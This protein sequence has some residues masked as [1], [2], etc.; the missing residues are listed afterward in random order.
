ML[1]GLGVSRCLLL[2]EGV[3]RC[4][5]CCCCGACCCCW[6]WWWCRGQYWLVIEVIAEVVCSWSLEA[7]RI[8]IPTPLAVTPCI[9]MDPLFPL[10]VFAFTM[11]KRN[12]RETIKRLSLMMSLL[13]FSD[14]Q[15][16]YFH[17]HCLTTYIPRQ[18][19]MYILAWAHFWSTEM[20]SQ[21]DTYCCLKIWCSQIFFF[22]SMRRQK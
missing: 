11:L 18:V 9:Q 8:V 4:C 10:P 13:D 2:G 1:W 5:C 17:V 12:T 22:L 6:V 20:H 16:S 3:W 15:D 14:F 21:Y 7:S 19:F